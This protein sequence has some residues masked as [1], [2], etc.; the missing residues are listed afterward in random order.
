MLAE[1]SSLGG[2]HGGGAAAVGTGAG[3]TAAFLLQAVVRQCRLPL[4]NPRCN[5]LELST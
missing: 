3:S 5:R 2:E 4:S 1:A